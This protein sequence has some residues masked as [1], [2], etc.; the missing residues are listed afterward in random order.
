M[1]FCRCAVEADDLQI[2][3]PEYLGCSHCLFETQRAGL[4]EDMAIL[5]DATE[6]TDPEISLE[7][8]VSVSI[9]ESAITHSP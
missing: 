9:S 2:L 8:L 6:L 7:L 1:V 5:T 3:F 4:M